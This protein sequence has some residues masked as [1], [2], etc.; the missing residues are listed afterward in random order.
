M[1]LQSHECQ[2]GIHCHEQLLKYTTTSL[3]GEDGTQS[4]A[5][6]ASRHMPPENACSLL[7]LGSALRCSNRPCPHLAG[8]SNVVLSQGESG[9]F[10]VVQSGVG[11]HARNSALLK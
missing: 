8:D 6:R 11:E 10:T 3:R 4:Q 5:K 7:W 1:H 2:L 9:G